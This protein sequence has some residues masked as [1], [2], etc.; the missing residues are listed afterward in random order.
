MLYFDFLSY[1][2]ITSQ[3]KQKQ[4]SAKEV[5]KCTEIKEIITHSKEINKFK[6]TIPEKVKASN[7]LDKDLKL[8]S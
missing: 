8:L 6:E 4:I 2:I 3:R 7:L 5:T 1:Y